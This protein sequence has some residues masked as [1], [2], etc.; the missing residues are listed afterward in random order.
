[1]SD[2]R[3]EEAVRAAA[4]RIAAQ[5]A[6]DSLRTRLALIPTS[7][8]HRAARRGSFAD[9]GL[10]GAIAA[11]VLVIVIVAIVSAGLPPLR[12]P[13]AAA[14]GSP[15]PIPSTP[16]TPTETTPSA[17]PS[18]SAN[19]VLP[20]SVKQVAVYDFEAELMAASESRLFGVRVES[21]GGSAVIFRIDPNGTVTNQLVQDPLAAYYSSLV[22]NGSSLYIG[23]SVI[24][25]FTDQAD[26]IIRLDS[27]TLSVTAR[28][29]LRGAVIG[30]AADADNVWVALADRVLRVDPNSLAIRSTTAIP[31][32][33]LT[34]GEP[35][36]NSF[37]HGPD[38]L[39]LTVGAAG[40]DVLY[41]LDPTDLSILGQTNL[42]D[43][44]QV[45][46]L[47]AGAEGAWLTAADW[48]QTIDSSGHTVTRTATPALQAAA[49]DGQALLALVYQGSS[50]EVLLRID[51][52]GG[53]VGSTE[54]GDTGGRI[55]VDGDDVWLLNGPSVIHWKLVTP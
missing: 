53:V 35:A 25:R 32:A 20:D 43:A 34:L 17:I 24:S 1:M 21:S 8:P 6:P 18:I 29:K 9:V 28:K 7:H 49:A 31:G 23:T 12:G 51:E 44:D 30:L 45:T 37:A 16:A 42:A 5:P 26:E 39:L 33:S 22:V 2:D 40:N 48:V 41:R 10:G 13:A 4:R 14:S 47:V 46:G 19:P 52:A 27:A 3:F 54:V 11:A 55:A 15:K 50:S 38:G 36:V